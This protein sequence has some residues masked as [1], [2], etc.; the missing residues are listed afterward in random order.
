MSLDYIWTELVVSVTVG[1]CAVFSLVGGYMADALG[2]RTTILIAS[3][4]FTFGAVLLGAAQEKILFLIGRIVV[5]CA[6]GIF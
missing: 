1:A 2:R 5:G 4:L 6:I 3:A